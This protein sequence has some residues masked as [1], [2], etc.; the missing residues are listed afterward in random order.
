[1]R[2]FSLRYSNIERERFCLYRKFFA[3][4]IIPLRKTAKKLKDAIKLGTMIWETC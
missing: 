2:K 1:M 4:I 3:T